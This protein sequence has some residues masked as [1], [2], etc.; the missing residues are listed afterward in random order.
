M[1]FD[2]TPLQVETR[3]VNVCDL[4]I[5]GSRSRIFLKMRKHFV[6]ILMAY[7]RLRMPLYRWVGAWPVG[8]D[9]ENRASGFS[10]Q[11]KHFY[12]YY[13]IGAE[14]RRLPI[15]VHNVVQHTR[16]IVAVTY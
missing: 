5:E 1:G 6:N 8:R 7:L 11:H 4:A 9:G 16:P 10:Q 13:P 2:R 15:H 12:I 3:R 14:L